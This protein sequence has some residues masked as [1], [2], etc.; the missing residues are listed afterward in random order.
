MN[1]NTVA[2]R[3][4][5]TVQLLSMGAMELSAPFWPVHLRNIGQ[6]SPTGLAWASAIAYAGPMLT[7]MCVTPIWGRIGDRIG[8]KPMLLRALLALAA[9]QW[10]IAST[11]SVTMI[12]VARL[13]Q[14]GLAGFIAASQAY[15]SGLVQR[16]K[17][18]SLMARLQIATALGATA[19]PVFGG[20]IFDAYGFE[21]VNVIATI[22]CLACAL[23]AW[24]VLP[25]IAPALPAGHASRRPGQPLAISAFQGLL[26]GIVLVQTGKMMPQSFFGLYAEQVLHASGW[27]TGLCYG[28]TALGLCMAAPYWGK[29]FE[30]RPRTVVLRESEIIC[31]LCVGII[32]IQAASRDTA[33]VVLARLLW[34]VCLA[35]LLPVFYGLLSR[36]AGAQDLGWVMAAGSSA[37][38]A[39]A[40]LGAGAGALALAWIPIEHLFWLVAATYA[41]IALGL[42]C[43]RHLT[44]GSP[45]LNKP[46]PPGRLPN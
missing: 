5:F 13:T 3:W 41:L 40:L 8:H 12:L 38:K 28:A 45:A 17:R 39:G 44:R 18:G 33:M 14:G 35:A 22:I 31:W 10:W 36:D 9:T 21:S 19:G 42:R 26:A 30:A 25:G 23:V 32:A 34:G 24:R 20:W 6:L 29:R 43:I 1:Q 27:I 2:L 37:A 15:G 7:A 46:A 4:L 16:E 11:D